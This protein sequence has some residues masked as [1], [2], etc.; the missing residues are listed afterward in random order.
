M[1]A[2]S[3]AR[4]PHQVS[5]ITCGF[6]G[7]T[8]G[9]VA[10]SHSS[11]DRP[12]FDLPGVCRLRNDVVDVLRE[13]LKTITE[14]HEHGRLGAAA[15]Q[16]KYPRSWQV[17]RSADQP[18]DRCHDALPDHHHRSVHMDVCVCAGGCACSN[19]FVGTAFFAFGRP[20]LTCRSPQ[21]TG[22]ARTRRP[23]FAAGASTLLTVPRAH[24]SGC[25]FR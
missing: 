19:S 12:C 2:S 6:A 24:H 20:P 9:T 14:L 4:E 15:L 23:G 22:A 17:V 18:K 25:D 11:L 13:L 16:M 10:R 5:R 21:C 8:S 7:P 3:S 1:E